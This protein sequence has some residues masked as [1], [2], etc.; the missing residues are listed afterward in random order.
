MQPVQFFI[1]SFRSSQLVNRIK[2]FFENKIPNNVS[3]QIFDQ[4]ANQSKAIK[5]QDRQHMYKHNS[6]LCS[7]NH[8]C[9]T[10]A[11]SITYSEYVS[12]A[13]VIQHAEGM[14][15]T[16]LSSVASLV[17]PYFSTLSHKRHNFRENVIE[18]K[19]VCFDFCYSFCPKHF[20]L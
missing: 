20:L 14:H 13:S 2:Y 18:H 15:L 11:I 17:L 19:N 12:V 16:I 3:T 8:C 7:C 4:C 10:K 6:E 5:Q 9:S 1:F